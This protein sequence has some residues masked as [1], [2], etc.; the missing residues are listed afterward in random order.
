MIK[1]RIT[2]YIA[3]M[4]VFTLFLGGFALP[5]Y[6]DDNTQDD[7]TYGY[8]FKLKDTASVNLR[9]L[10]ADDGII[11]L[12]KEEPLYL[13]PDLA[14]IQ[15]Y[16]D[17]NDVAYIVPNCPIQ[18]LDF[19]DTAP[20]DPYYPNQWNLD[21]INIAAAWQKGFYGQGVTV[22]VIDSGLNVGHE[23]LTGLQVT[24]K[25][26]TVTYSDGLTQNP[27]NYTDDQ[28]HGSFVTGIIAADIN[29]GTGVSGMTD[30]VKVVALRVFENGRGTLAGLILALGAAVDDYDCDVINMS[31]GTTGPTSLELAALQDAIDYAAGKG[32]CSSR[33]GQCRQQHPVLSGGLRACHRCGFGGCFP[34]SFRF[35]SEE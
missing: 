23:D 27:T 3:L 29:N 26:F 14:S 21:K 31:L 9:L 1:K 16:T 2:F 8:I 10:D 25:N 34:D 4:M 19:P 22:G 17:E 35:F 15:N 12:L 32:R 33:G 11:E 18:L 6:G 30:Q 13:A 7:G 28:G 20:D 24:G 5:A